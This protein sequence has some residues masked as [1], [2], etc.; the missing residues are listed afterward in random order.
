MSYPEILPKGPVCHHATGCGH[1]FLDDD[2]HGHQFKRFHFFLGG[3]FSSFQTDFAFAFHCVCFIL[4]CRCIKALNRTPRHIHI[5]PDPH[6]N[7]TI[8]SPDHSHPH[9]II[10]HVILTTSPR[11]A[12]IGQ[13]PSLHPLCSITHDDVVMMM[14]MMVRTVIVMVI[15]MRGQGQERGRERHGIGDIPNGCRH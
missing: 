6:Q 12:P 4:I 8:S 10:T 1:A 2:F 5:I 15:V 14:A 3:G 7:I 11:L 9:H 13:Q